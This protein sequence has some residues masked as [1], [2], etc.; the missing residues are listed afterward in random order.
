M[1]APVASR[2]VFSSPSSTPPPSNMADNHST[3]SPTREM[4]KF[5]LHAVSAPNRQVVKQ[6]LLDGELELRGFHSE[7]NRLKAKIT[8]LETMR[9]ALNEKLRKY[10]SLLSPIHRLPPE[11]LVEI[12]RLSYGKGYLGIKAVPQAILLSRVCSRW[13]QVTLSAPQLWASVCV[14][15]TI[16]TKSGRR[17]MGGSE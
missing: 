9:E 12:F 16:W 10:K 4:Q 15:F 7:I 8:V 5:F 11:V 17:S 2:R 3:T 14:P 13:R 1:E 6:Y